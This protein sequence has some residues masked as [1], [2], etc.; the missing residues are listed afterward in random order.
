MFDLVV[1]FLFILALA[2][3]ARALMGAQGLTW[4]R[5]L[6]A[7]VAGLAMGDFIALMMVSDLEDIPNVDF[8]QLQVISMPFRLLA[9][10]G[11]LVVLELISSSTRRPRRRF[12]AIRALRGLGRTVVRGVRVLSI[13]VRRGLGPALGLRRGDLSARDPAELARQVRLAMEDAGGM[14]VKLGQLLAT[15]PDLLPPPAVAEL[16]RLHAGA[17]PLARPEIEAVI[18]AEIGPLTDTFRSF[19]W[20]PLGSASIAQVHAAELPDGRQVV[21]KVQRPGLEDV[22]ETDLRIVNWLARMAARRTDWGQAYAIDL[23]AEEFSASLRTELDF[24][25]EARHASEADAWLDHHPHVDGPAVVDH[26]TTRRVLVMELLVGTPLSN[27]AEPVDP[28]TARQLAD[29]LCR[30]QVTAML[31]GERFHGDPHPGNVLI[32]DTDGLG[33]IDFGVTG[34]LDAFERSSVFQMLVALRLEHPT[35]LYEAMVS[36]GAVG[37][38]HDPDEIERAFAQFMAAYLGSGLPPPDAL[39]DLLRLTTELRLHLPASTTTMF[40]ALATL[41][42]TL[43]Q[44]S[45]GYPLIEAVAEIGGDEFRQRIAPDSAREFVQQEWA[46]LAPLLSRA[47]RH[48]DRLATLAESGRLTTRLRLFSDPEDIRVLEQF[49]NRFLLTL[50][51]IGTGAVSVMLLGTEG[52]PIIEAADVPLLEILGWIGLS[53]AVILLLRVLL[54]VLRS[55]R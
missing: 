7:T 1:S 52:G 40:R 33:L 21:V 18:S 43:E 47:P 22:V 54:A 6:L 19:D 50:L 36:I 14:F 17:S 10:M 37:P 2:W 23:L 16:G 39:T 48:F 11:A 4:P 28:E 12:R 53:L 49:H 13:A 32:L 30:S 38:G 3:L 31:Q 51:S 24:R 8:E 42:G 45:P 35:L 41:A 34:R 44:L 15:R 5:L 9:T 25:I 20:D 26:L 27:L 29:A 46:R 55:D